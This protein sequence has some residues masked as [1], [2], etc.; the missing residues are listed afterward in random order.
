MRIA[1]LFSILFS[2]SVTLL[3]VSAAVS[4]FDSASKVDRP[5]SVGLVL[6]GGGAKGIAHIGVIRALED[7]NIPIDYI[8]GTSMGAIIGGLYACG[9]TTDEMMDLLLSRGFSYWSTGKI[10]P[11]LMD[12]FSRP[13]ITPSLMD[14]SLPPRDS[15]ARAELDSVPASI[16]NA[17]P[18]NFAFMDLFTAYT[19]QCGG[20]FNRLFV[21]FRCVAS[22]VDANHKVVHASGNLGEAIRTSMSFPIVFQPIRINGRL[23]YDG[24]IFDNFPVDVMLNDFA[25]DIMIGVDVSASDKGPQTSLLDQVNNLVERRQTYDL[26]GDKGIKIRVNLDEFSLLDFP[27]AKKIY[28]IGYAK[29]M[30]MID[31]IKGRVTS[32]ITPEARN[33]ARDVFKSNSPYVRF[34]EVTVDGGDRQQRRYIRYLFEPAHSDTFGIAHAREAYYRAITPGRLRDLYPTA[35]YVDSTGLFDLHL[36]LTPKSNY[37]IGLGG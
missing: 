12:Y 29:A 21:P 26:P 9:Y 23:L 6:S 3:P 7:A 32:R 11:D 16:I 18:M 10:D 1:R 28:D 2:L 25:P 35:T 19:A 17:L 27:A 36:Q 15:L 4:D 33:T 24:G 20:D 31:S 34:S 13:P 14:I 22:D 8:T 30:T 5:Q 37:G